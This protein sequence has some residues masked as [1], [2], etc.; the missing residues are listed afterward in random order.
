MKY[1]ETFIYVTF[2][3]S[4]HS[5]MFI[6]WKSF[7]TNPYHFWLKYLNSNFNVLF[8]IDDLSPLNEILSEY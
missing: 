5:G 1:R 3:R 4:I 8:N 7:S 2:D 6:A